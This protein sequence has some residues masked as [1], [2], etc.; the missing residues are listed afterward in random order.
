MKI[1]TQMMDLVWLALVQYYPH[2]ESCKMR[3]SSIDSVAP[4][5][6]IAQYE[7]EYCQFQAEDHIEGK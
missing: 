2:V 7:W 6:D 5:A 4:S 1:A 3:N